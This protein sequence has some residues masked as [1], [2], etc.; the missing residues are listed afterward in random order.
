MRTPPPGSFRGRPYIEG[1]FPSL[2]QDTPKRLHD[3][4]AGG[5]TENQYIVF[6]VDSIVDILNPVTGHQSMI[7][8]NTKEKMLSIM[9]NIYSS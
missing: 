7:S 8:K 6:I 1:L 5:E 4:N 2:R 3:R 9:F